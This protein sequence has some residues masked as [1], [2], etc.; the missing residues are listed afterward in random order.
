[1]SS[2]R[3]TETVRPQR[4]QIKTNLIHQHMR[5]GPCIVVM[6]FTSHYS[7]YF[8]FKVLHVNI[9]TFYGTVTIYKI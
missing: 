9:E 8:H 4:M 5:W 6:K 2:F 3:G 7:K 1:M